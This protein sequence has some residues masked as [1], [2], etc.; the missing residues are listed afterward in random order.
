MI[1]QSQQFHRRHANLIL[2]AG[3]NLV[4]RDLFRTIVVT[5]SLAAIL[6]PFLAA[7]SI[8]EGIKLQSNVSVEEGADFYVTRDAAGSSAPMP[9]GDIERFRKLQGVARVVPRIVGRAY[10]KERTITV[11]GMPG[12]TVPRSL[13]VSGGRKIEK[14]GEVVVGSTLSSRYGLAP[15]SKFYMPINRWKRFTV[16]GVFSSGCSIWS[17]L[18]R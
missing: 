7:L 9:L 17:F 15:G 1:A 5:L 4:R 6:F 13:L 2:A 18:R 14:K 16:V 3:G 8:S 12:G 10:L 11:V